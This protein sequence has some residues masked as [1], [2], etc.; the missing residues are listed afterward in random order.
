MENLKD[1]NLDKE[2]E[3]INNISI[4]ELELKLEKPFQKCKDLKRHLERI[5]NIRIDLIKKQDNL[6]KV[7]VII[8]AIIKVVKSQDLFIYLYMLFCHSNG[9]YLHLDPLPIII[10][11]LNIE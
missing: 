8:V 5:N 6:K 3:N 11:N 7:I 4:Q 10:K 9:I 2:N 1:N